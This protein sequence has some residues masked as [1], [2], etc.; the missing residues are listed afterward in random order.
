MSVD[1]LQ[2]PRPHNLPSPSEPHPGLPG[3]ILVVGTVGWEATR[4]GR[5]CQPGRQGKNEHRTTKAWTRK[6]I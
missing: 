6:C 4:Q 5:A 3:T 1:K 2:K